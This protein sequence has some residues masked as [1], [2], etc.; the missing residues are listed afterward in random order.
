[1]YFISQCYALNNVLQWHAFTP[2]SVRLSI[3]FL[4]NKGQP[5]L[6]KLR[7]IKGKENFPWRG[8]PKFASHPKVE[9]KVKCMNNNFKEMVHNPNSSNADKNYDSDC[10]KEW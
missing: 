8:S 4:R 7:A 3:R 9:K 1:M 5:K 10:C 2:A 6:S